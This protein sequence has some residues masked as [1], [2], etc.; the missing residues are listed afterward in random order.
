VFCVSFVGFRVGFRGWSCNVAWWTI[1][2]HASSLARG[3]RLLRAGIIII[4]YW[5]IVC[6][7]AEIARYI[8]CILYKISIFYVLYPTPEKSHTCT[9]KVRQGIRNLIKVAAC[10]KQAIDGQWMSNK[11][12]YKI[13]LSACS[14][15]FFEKIQKKRKQEKKRQQRKRQKLG[16]T[17]PHTSTATHTRTATQKHVFLQPSSC[18]IYSHN[19]AQSPK[20]LGLRNLTIIMARWCVHA[21]LCPSVRP[22]MPGRLTDKGIVIL[23]Y[24]NKKV[25]RSFKET[26]GVCIN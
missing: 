22:R 7:W 5:E 14:C 2:A 10:D 11:H 13:L 26:V 6:H 21:S 25:S 20:G 16:H 19:R 9:V 23:L 17:Q 4:S 15:F 8:N 18:H 1:C 24:G 12:K 3:H